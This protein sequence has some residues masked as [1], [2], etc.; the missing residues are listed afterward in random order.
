ME[1]LLLL[2]VLVLVM[3]PSAWAKDEGKE[4]HFSRF[5]GHSVSDRLQPACSLP[6]KQIDRIFSHHGACI[7]P[8]VSLCTIA[9]RWQDFVIALSPI[10]VTF[11]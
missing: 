2:H 3:L 7:S 1:S 5:F 6:C 9:N 8:F 11:N 4:V 10:F